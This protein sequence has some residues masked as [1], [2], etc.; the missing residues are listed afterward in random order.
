[1]RVCLLPL[2]IEP[3]DPAKNLR[4]FEQRLQ[5]IA[6]HQPDLICLPECAFTGYLY[7]EADLTRFAEPIPGGMTAAISQL[8]RSYHSFICFG[9]LEG[10]PQ[11]VYSSAVLVD[12][13]SQVSLV[14]R[15]IIEQPPFATGSEVHIA[16]TEF[17]WMS[18][19]ICGDLF[20]DTVKSRIDPRTQLLLVPLARSFEGKSPDLER[21]LKEERQ[22]YLDEV[23]KTGI[24]TLMVNSLEDATIPEAAFGGALIVRGDGAVLAESPHGSDQA[25]IFDLMPS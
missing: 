20:D 23:K 16:D 4:H 10:T 21:W 17:G 1:M 13:A 14:Q 8:A 22:T 5:E 11:G 19:L 24:L 18:I 6:P 12:R 25:L 15:K 9:M 3:G 7:E 2:K